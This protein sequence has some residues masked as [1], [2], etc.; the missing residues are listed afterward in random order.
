MFEY[1]DNNPECKLKK[2]KLSFCKFDSKM[3]A[4]AIRNDWLDT[5]SFPDEK[6]NHP[7]KEEVFEVARQFQYSSDFMKNYPRHYSAATVYGW[8]KE[9]TWFKR[10]PCGHGNKPKTSRK[11]LE[12][13]LSLKDIEFNDNSNCDYY[14]SDRV[15]VKCKKCGREWNIRLSNI[16]NGSGCVNCF[17]EK[18][19]RTI[20][21]GDRFGNM[22]VLKEIFDSGRSDRAFLCRCDC[23]DESVQN[24]YYLTT[25]ENISCTKCKHKEVHEKIYDKSYNK[26]KKLCEECGSELI[27]RREE[28][29]G[30]GGTY[31]VRCMRCKTITECSYGSILEQSLYCN[32]CRSE[33]ASEFYRMKWEDVQNVFLTRGI[34]LISSESD[35]RNTSSRLKFKCKNCGR[36]VE[37]LIGE[38]YNGRKYCTICSNKT[39]T[40]ERVVY[41]VLVDIFEGYKIES[42][43]NGKQ[44]MIKTYN[45]ELGKV[46]PQYFDFYIDELKLAI[47]TNGVYHF[48]K[49]N[50]KPEMREKVELTLRRDKRKQKWCE[51]NDVTL[52][53]IDIPNFKKYSDITKERIVE[54]LLEN[55][56]DI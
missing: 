28:F 43:I 16:L 5:I 13:I 8:L 39:S 18:Q 15:D 9:M 32:K 48:L 29:K 36:I 41:D 55:N 40:F 7:S 20:L 30:M 4:A 44:H 27:T 12:E 35:Y 11:E 3:Y 14:K 51:D 31:K 26:L 45:E 33:N 46:T 17:N 53:N 22:T 34:E 37:G 10:K 19:K 1:I 56:V 23:G 52:V 47:E 42:S 38:V 24:M 54:I 25:V 2:N 49:N 6:Q 50:M 21:P